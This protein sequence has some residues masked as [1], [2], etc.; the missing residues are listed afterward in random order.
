DSKASPEAVFEVVAG[1][2]AAEGG[3]IPER[4]VLVMQRA[5]VRYVAGAVVGLR[6]ALEGVCRGLDCGVGMT[7]VEGACGVSE[8]ATVE[9]G[10]TQ[11]WGRWMLGSGT[12]T[13]GRTSGW[14][15]D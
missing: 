14:M 15:S 12:M 3:R 5:R 9:G 7:C 2:C 11:V 1:G 10:W 8:S 13:S 6:M 4:C